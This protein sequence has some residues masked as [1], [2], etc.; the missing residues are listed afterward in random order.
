M[1][2]HFENNGLAVADIDDAGVLARAANHLRASGGQLLEVDFGGLV[3]AML[4]PHGR[5]HTQFGEGRFTVQ[6]T[7]NFGVFVIVDAMG[8]NQFGGDSGV[9]HARVLGLWP[10]AAV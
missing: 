1:A 4:V 8:S 3:R 2:F 7:Q 5:E 9:L 6:D 10:V